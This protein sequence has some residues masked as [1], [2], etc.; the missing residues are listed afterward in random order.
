MNM[1]KLTG[2][3]IILVLLSAGQLVKSQS[4]KNQFQVI[5]EV[6]IPIE[7]Y[8][9]GLGGQLKWLCRLGPAGQLTISAGYS[10]FRSSDKSVGGKRASLRLIPFMAG[11]RRNIDRFFVEPQAGYGELGGRVDI[12]GDYARPSVGAF[13][14]ALGAGYSLK[15]LDVGVR[16]L[17]AHGAQ[18][19]EGGMWYN[20]QFKY[21]GFFAAYNLRRALN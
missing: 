13:F 14:W 18:S 10:G 4:I 11:Y 20:A 19:S 15:R 2:A 8:G 5:G 6:A 1:K 7:D 21:V 3:L 12:G 16:Y 9:P 17:G